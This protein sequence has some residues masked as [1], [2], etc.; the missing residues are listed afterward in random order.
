MTD[1][2]KKYVKKIRIRKL[3]TKVLQIGI[4]LLFIGLWELVAQKEIIDPFIISS[5]SRIFKLLLKLE[6]QKNL[7]NHLSATLI[8]TVLGF[9][10][11]TAAGTLIAIILWWSRLLND[12]LEPYLVTLNSLPKIALGPLIIIWIGAGK[13]AIITMAIL[14]CIIITIISMLSGF[15]Q[16]DK[17]KIML[18]KSMQAN[19]FQILTKLVLPANIPTLISVLKINVGLSWVGT[20]MGEY[21]VSREGIGYLIVYG[22]Q[23]FQL[24]LVMA[25]T[26]ILCILAALMYAIVA[27]I[28]KIIKKYF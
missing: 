18:L 23:V 21:L 25:S 24:D 3:V 16:V 14:I 9:L 4:L 11:S 22:S 10:I 2:H 15:M 20:I 6:A 12:V 28:E 8:E 1:E 13:Q 17:E 5:P 27:L 7:F 19:K 26:V